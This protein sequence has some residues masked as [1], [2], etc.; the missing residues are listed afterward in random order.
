M[1]LFFGEITV[2]GLLLLFNMRRM[3]FI[4]PLIH[5]HCP[6][7]IDILSQKKCFPLAKGQLNIKK[8]GACGIAL[9]G[10]IPGFGISQLNCCER[11]KSLPNNPPK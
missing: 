9:L 7:H 8:Q 5:Q 11:G 6:S 4:E 2:K 1:S 10:T 3:I